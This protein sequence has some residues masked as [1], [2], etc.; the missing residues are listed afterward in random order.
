MYLGNID[1][2]SACEFILKDYI[3]TNEVGFTYHNCKLKAI[4]RGERMKQEENLEEETC[5]QN[6][7]QVQA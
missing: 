2:W 6:L 3:R 1:G 7:K 4:I 5:Q